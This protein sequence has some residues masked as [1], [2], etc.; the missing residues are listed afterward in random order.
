MKKGRTLR[1]VF[2]AFAIACTMHMPL[3]A[4]DNSTQSQL[5]DMQNAERERLGIE[6]LAWSD[7][8]AEQA[9]EWADELA[10]RGVMQHSPRD[11]RPD[12]GENL[13]AGS[14][15][16]YQP[17][18]M[19]N[20]FIAERQYFQNNEFPDVTTTDRWQDV[21]HYTQIVWRDTREV[22]CAIAEGNDFEFLVCRYFPAGNYIGERAY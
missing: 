1:A 12:I 19:I 22:G 3:G 7:I 16:F 14:A 10:Q 5:L 2:T 21:G 17:E 6:P 20:A 4:Q 13:W 15:G 18:D 8:L 9:Q 11:T